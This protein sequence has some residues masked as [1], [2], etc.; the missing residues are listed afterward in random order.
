[1]SSHYQMVLKSGH[2]QGILPDGPDGWVYKVG[3][4]KAGRILDGKT[5]DEFPFVKQ[6]YI[7]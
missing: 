3:K 1:M 5:H 6:L 2:L 4:K 7:S